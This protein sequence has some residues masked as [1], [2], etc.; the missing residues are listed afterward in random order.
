M[1][2]WS[3]RG[4]G[5]GC[6]CKRIDGK[7]GKLLKWGIWSKVRMWICWLSLFKAWRIVEMHWNSRDWRYLGG[8]FTGKDRCCGCKWIDG[9]GGG[10]KLGVQ[11]RMTGIWSAF[12]RDQQQYLSWLWRIACKMVRH[13]RLSAVCLIVKAKIWPFQKFKQSPHSEGLRDTQQVR[14]PEH[15]P[16]W[17][18]PS[19]ARQRIISQNLN[20]R[21]I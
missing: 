2:W 3:I 9:V 19:F 16:R 6:W 7:V 18:F 4:K 1:S 21:A 11:T 15:S 12:L 8:M 13:P 10:K 17:S 5:Y 14:L 20:P